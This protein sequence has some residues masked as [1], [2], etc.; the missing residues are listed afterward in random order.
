MGNR[1]YV[2]NLKLK[3]KSSISVNGEPKFSELST[4]S[5]TS[6]NNTITQKESAVNNYYAG[7]SENDT[8]YSIKKETC[9][10]AWLWRP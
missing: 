10:K 3:K 2:H 6:Y 1:F 7:N 4:K 8:R 5:Q 9:F